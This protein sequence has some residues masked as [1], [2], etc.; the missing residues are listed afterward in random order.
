[1]ELS[2][3]NRKASAFNLHV[4]SWQIAARSAILAAQVGPVKSGAFVHILVAIGAL[5]IVCTLAHVA[6][7]SWNASGAILT[8]VRAAS[9]SL[10]KPPHSPQDSL[11]SGNL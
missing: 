9:I 4:G 10:Q 1:M 3:C 11:Q 5:P 8:R 2:Y 7:I 6:P